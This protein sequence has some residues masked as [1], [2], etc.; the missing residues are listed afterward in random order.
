MVSPLDIPRPVRSIT[1]LKLY[2]LPPQSLNSMSS[3]SPFIVS[4]FSSC[5]V[6]DSWYC[7]LSCAK[8]FAHPSH[9]SSHRCGSSGVV[10]PWSRCCCH[11]CSFTPPA[12]ESVSHCC[13]EHTSCSS[14]SW[15]ASIASLLGLPLHPSSVRNGFHTLA[16]DSTPVT[17][18][19]DDSLLWLVT[20]LM[21][22]SDMLL[23]LTAPPESIILL[24]SCISARNSCSG[25]AGIGC[26]RCGSGS[27][28]SPSSVS[29]VGQKWRVSCCA[30]T[31]LPCGV[32]HHLPA[33][34]IN[35]HCCC[36]CTPSLIK[37]VTM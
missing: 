28:A 24:D 6:L 29:M 20:G 5:P 13:A 10:W 2:L 14:C 17:S 36:T 18:S 26:L 23:S 30:A 21:L 31:K 4:S 16:A 34:V 37:V 19:S 1:A 33:G 35:F 3:R 7:G 9:F 25:S 22:S 15:P 32:K 8:A 12:V 11:A 27:S